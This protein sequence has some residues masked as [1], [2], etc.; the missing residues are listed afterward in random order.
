M[1]RFYYRN[2]SHADNKHESGESGQD[3]MSTSW[4]LYLNDLYQ[5]HVI[6]SLKIINLHHQSKSPYLYICVNFKACN[7]V[8]V[9]Y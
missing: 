1:E 6:K 4:I 3:C 7:D 8:N 5:M 2:N 9:L